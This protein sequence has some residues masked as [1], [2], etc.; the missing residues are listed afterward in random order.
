MKSR[1]APSSAHMRIKSIA[2]RVRCPAWKQVWRPTRNMQLRSS[3]RSKRPR[4]NFRRLKPSR[5]RNFRQRKLNTRLPWPRW[6]RNGQRR[7]LRP[8][9]SFQGFPYVPRGGGR[10]LRAQTRGRGHSPVPWF[11][12]AA[13]AWPQ[14]A[15]AL[16]PQRLP[17]SWP[18]H[19]KRIDSHKPSNYRFPTELVPR[20][21][22]AGAAPKL[23]LLAC[24][25]PPY[26]RSRPCHRFPNMGNIAN[27]QIEASGPMSFTMTA[28]CA[29]RR[30][31]ASSKISPAWASNTLVVISSSRW[32]GRQCCTMQSGLAASITWSFT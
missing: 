27:S 24:H 12:F 11:G 30:F 16:S 9:I 4:G 1:C 17:L 26:W 6:G 22:K 28:F 8:F 15:A 20:Q 25:A 32:A 5:R 13:R 23:C 21:Q 7:S 10:A 14:N 29:C 2:Y 18:G 3:R 31:S 19:P